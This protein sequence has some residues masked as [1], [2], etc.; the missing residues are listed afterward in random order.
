MAE[1]IAELREQR[2]EYLGEAAE[3]GWSWA[4][5]EASYD[6]LRNIFALSGVLEE[7]GFKV[8]RALNGQEAVDLAAAEPSIDIVLMDIMMPV[9]DGLEAI[10]QIRELGR[11]MP[12]LAVTAKATQGDRQQCLEVGADDFVAKPV[13]AD[14]LVA[15]TRT[16]ITR[17]RSNQSTNPEDTT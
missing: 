4:L 12:I 17:A 10:R 13:D 5:Q 8:L 7:Y 14:T 16:W 3:R 6:D 1:R 2:R 11:A 9:M 15:L